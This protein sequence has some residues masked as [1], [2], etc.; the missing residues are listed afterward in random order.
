MDA[1][2]VSPKAKASNSRCSIYK[3]KDRAGWKLGK[4][5]FLSHLQP[6]GDIQ[7]EDLAIYDVSI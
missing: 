6:H 3:T 2:L 5:K 4:D 7:S 1:M